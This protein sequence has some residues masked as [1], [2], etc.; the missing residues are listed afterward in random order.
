MHKIVAVNSPGDFVRTIAMTEW[1]YTIVSQWHARPR[2]GRPG[3][4]AIAADGS[5]H[6]IEFDS[7]Q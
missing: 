1:R 7:A 2:I 3:V 4:E 5:V 6:R